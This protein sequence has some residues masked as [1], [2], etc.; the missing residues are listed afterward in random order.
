MSISR[1][2]KKIQ[3]PPE[4]P[5]QNDH[6]A[7]E[8]APQIGTARVERVI[9][10]GDGLLRLDGKAGFI[11]GVLPGELVSFAV[12]RDRS[13]QF[14]GV[15]REVL[16]PSPHRCEP[17]CPLAGRCGGCDWQYCHSEYQLELKKGIVAEN[18]RRIGKI[19]LERESIQ[20]L[21]GEPWGYRERVQIHTD[22]R[23]RPGFK[24]RRSEEIV[25]LS[26]CPVVT[27]EINRFLEDAASGKILLPPGKRLV[28]VL[29]DGESPDSRAVI[30]APGPQTAQ[31]SLDGLPLSF[32]PSSFFQANGPLLERLGRELRS[33]IARDAPRVLVDL[34]GGAGVLGA[35]AVS[36]SSAFSGDLL[37]VEEDR[38]NARFIGEN[39]LRAGLKE[40]RIRVVSRSAEKALAVDPVLKN[41]DPP[42]SAVILDPP[43]SGL[44]ATLRRWLKK[45]PAARLFYVSCNSATLARDLGEILGAYLIQDVTILDFFPQTAHVEVLVE[46]RLKG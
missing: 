38:R 45:G 13:R 30:V 12:L 29:A 10:G 22:H 35:L 40:A 32:D 41:L 6:S 34:Y 16:D 44:S 1:F 46:L 2:D 9:H 7:P 14:E 31:R 19:L 15:L 17:R 27:E 24:A 36:G 42:S 25:L 20:I 11:S 18:L 5:C 3:T 21:A 26:S 43:R 8:E 23:G 39:L 33:R 4:N 28:L 37:C